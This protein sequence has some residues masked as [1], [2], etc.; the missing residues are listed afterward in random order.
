MAVRMVQRLKNFHHDA[1]NVFQRKPLVGVKVAAQLP[2]LDKLHGDECHALGG[3]S[4]EV[5]A[6][7]RRRGVFDLDFAVF[8]HSNNAGMIQPSRCLRLAL[9]PG[10]HGVHLTAVKLR[11]QDGL[12]GDGALQ[13]RVEPLVHDAHGT[14]AQCSAYDV[15]TEFGQGR[16][17]PQ[18]V[19][20]QCA[21][22]F[23]SVRS[24]HAFEK[25]CPF[26]Q[27]AHGGMVLHRPEDPLNNSSRPVLARTRAVCGVEFLANSGAIGCKI[28]LAAHP[29]P[30]FTDSR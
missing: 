21:N 25:I 26:R 20:K 28:R 16:H 11:R 12:D 13:N 3:R 14:L 24:P 17:G 23:A 29:D 1:P 18:R 8:I 7:Q 5:R 15:L 9:E 10:Q 2:A 19:R 6:G 27:L 22:G 30:A 4:R